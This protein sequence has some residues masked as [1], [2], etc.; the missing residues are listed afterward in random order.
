M[1]IE[2]ALSTDE[3]KRAGNP[4]SMYTRPIDGWLTARP[5]G[6][7]DWRDGYF[8]FE[9]TKRPHTAIALYNAKLPDS[10]PRKI[11]REKIIAMRR[12]ADELHV[13]DA[14]NLSERRAEMHAWADALESYLPPLTA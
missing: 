8:A 11:T 9:A 13:Y 6:A 3:W 2:P 14:L 12:A 10:D 7:D 1:K 5:D 4:P